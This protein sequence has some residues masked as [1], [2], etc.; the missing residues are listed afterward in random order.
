M[1]TS[2]TMC[3]AHIMNT[4]RKLIDAS[5]PSGAFVGKICTGPVIKNFV[6]LKAPAK[7]LNMKERMGRPWALNRLKL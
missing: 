2:L 7:E 1:H 3:I 6:T 4:A 5:P